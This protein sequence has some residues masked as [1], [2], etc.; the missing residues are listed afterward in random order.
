MLDQSQIGAHSKR[1]VVAELE[2]RHIGM[3][4]GDAALQHAG[5]FIKIDGA[6][7]RAERRRVRVL[8]LSFDSDCMAAATELSDQRLTMGGWIL[9]LRGGGR[10]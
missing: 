1:V 3:T 10:K 6:P 8:A 5:K 2:L 4:A 7:E 9:R